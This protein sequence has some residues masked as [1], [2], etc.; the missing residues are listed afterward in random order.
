M[1]AGL[2]INTSCQVF[3]VF[4]PV[5]QPVY[6][7]RFSSQEDLT[8]AGV[9]CQVSSESAIFIVHSWCMRVSKSS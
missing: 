7:V 4:G 1:S 3:D 8:K 2:S 9:R 6:A 5:K